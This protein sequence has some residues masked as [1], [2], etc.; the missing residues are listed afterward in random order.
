MLEFFGSILAL[1][2]AL[3]YFWLIF[4]G[5]A[6]LASFFVIKERGF[7]STVSTALLIALLIG[8]WETIALDP[9]FA[10]AGAVA[11]LIAGLFWA[12]YQWGRLLTRNV[13]TFQQI[14]DSFLKEMKLPLDYFKTVDPS[15]VAAPAAEGAEID[16]RKDAGQTSK[17]G[18]TPETMLDRY[19][20]FVTSMVGRDNIAYTGKVTSLK[21]FHVALAPQASNHKGSIVMWITYWP[22]S[23]LWYVLKDVIADLNRALYNLVAGRFQKM[24]TERFE[25]L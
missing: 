3:P 6:F 16:T 9:L 4:V 14:R 18:S 5:I 13:E 25:Q 20:T 24:A 19:V 23:S 15:T 8:K 10:T 21:Q 2:I 17:E 22:V 7:Y 1:I 12:R 11:Y